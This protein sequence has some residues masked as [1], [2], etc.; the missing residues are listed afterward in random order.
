MNESHQTQ[1]EITDYQNCLF[2]FIRLFWK[3]HKPFVNSIDYKDDVFILF[4]QI[5][6]I[7]LHTVTTESILVKDKTKVLGNGKI[8][9]KSSIK[10]SN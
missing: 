4:W 6:A 1:T 2:Q 9:I 3:A 8:V 10:K 7:H 5:N